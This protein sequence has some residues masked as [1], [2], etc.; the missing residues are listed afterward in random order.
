[1]RLCLL[2]LKT[3]DHASGKEK[4]EENTDGKKSLEALFSG[5]FSLQAAAI[6]DTRSVPSLP[7]FRTIGPHVIFRCKTVE[8]LWPFK[9]CMTE[10]GRPIRIELVIGLQHKT[11]GREFLD[12]PV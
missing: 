11:G 9:N 4:I 12:L 6:R 5:E 10:P 8:K 1:M 2:I 3:L 7:C